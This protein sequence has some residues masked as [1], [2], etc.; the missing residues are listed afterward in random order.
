MP[1]SIRHVAL[2]AAL[3]GAVSPL[4]AQKAPALF[5]PGTVQEIRLYLHPNDW[6]TLQTNYLENTYYQADFVWQ[7]QQLPAVGIRSRGRGSRNANKPG[8]RV[9]FNRFVPG[10]QLLGLKSI[11]LDNMSQ[12][13]SFV[14][15][16]LSMALFAR[17][18]IPAPREAFCRLFINDRYH[19]LYAVVE[20]IDKEFLKRTLGEDE[21]YLYEYSWSSEY[22][23]NDLGE[24]PAAYVPLPF[25]PETHEQN[26][27]PA[28]L[29]AMVRAINHAPDESFVEEVSQY[30]D[31]RQFLTYLAVEAFIAEHDGMAGYVGMNNFYL[32]QMKDSARH[33]FISWDK[34]S[35]FWE[36]EQSPVW[37]LEL[38]VLSRRLLE[39]PEYRAFYF[40]TLQTMALESGGEENWMFQDSVFAH[41][42]ISG[43]VADDP[44]K[45][46]GYGDFESEL[47]YVQNFLR[48]RTGAILQQLDELRNPTQ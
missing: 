11:V 15:E 46:L 3:L 48:A 23:F 12:D 1:Y 2:A 26:P 25:K 17:M 28:A 19:G 16:R 34:D 4:P 27:N 40:D 30:L 32:Y 18:G 20:S 29:V 47:V 9:D 44:N 31:P 8:L 39:R 21:G 37:N 42:L 22:Y 45:P 24:D 6:A 7:D 33:V 38:N 13:P 36:Y 14:K 43:A 5:D 10:Q 41:D 35:P